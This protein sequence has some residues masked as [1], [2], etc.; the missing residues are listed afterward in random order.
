MNYRETLFI[1]AEIALIF[2]GILLVPLFVAVGLGESATVHAFGVAVVVSIVFG[3]VGVLCR[4]PKDKRAMKPAAAIM[5]CGIAWVLIAVIGAIPYRLSGCIPNYLDALFETVSGVT[6]T[7]ATVMRDVE[8][9]PKSILL[10]RAMSQWIGGMG[11]LIFVIAVLPKNESASTQLAKAEMPGPQFGKLVGKLR[12]TAQILYVIY[13]ALTLLE[14]GILV[15]CKMPV[16]D[17]FCHAFANAATGGFSVKNASIHAYDSVGI[18]IVI[19]VFTLLFSVN[20]NVF[21]LLLIGQWRKA[22]KNEET[23]WLFGI[24]IFATVSIS[25]SLFITNL[26]EYDYLQALRYSSFQVATVMSTTGFSSMNFS[27]WPV[28]AQFLLITLMFI[29]GSAGST[30]GGIKI[31]RIAILSKSS[32]LN[33]KKTLSPRSVSTIKM[34]GKPVNEEVVHSVQRFFVTYIF[35]FIISTLLISFLSPFSGSSGM[36][37]NISAVSTCLNNVGVGV[38]SLSNGVFADFN[39]FSKIVLMFDMLLGRLELMPMLLI[40]IPKLWKPVKF[41]ARG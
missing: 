38:L 14:V 8:I 16:F 23:W 28:F 5:L 19:T 33:F 3:I 9:M 6:T 7:G 40:F 25:I 29:G 20:F 35:I 21:F 30:A 11:V 17:S 27:G 26:N 13:I 22:V 24:Y 31:S 1:L 32:F 15:A 12:F 37:M 41:N 18:E 4:P 36:I 2:A 39:Y 10:W 34:D